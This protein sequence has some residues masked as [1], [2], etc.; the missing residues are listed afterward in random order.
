MGC[1][2]SRR[3]DAT[4]A[5]SIVIQGEPS[6]KLIKRG[7]DAQPWKPPKT[8]AFIS[9]AGWPAHE[10]PF[11]SHA[12]SSFSVPILSNTPA[13]DPDPDP[14][15]GAGQLR[16]SATVPSFIDDGGHTS[17]DIITVC[18]TDDGQAV[19]A[20]ASH[21]YSDF[22]ALH[23][24]L[25]SKQVAMR[26]PFPVPKKMFTSEHVKNE[27]KAQLQNYLNRLIELSGDSPPSALLTFLG[28]NR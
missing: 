21:R 12:G 4:A 3:R 16:L 18:T 6:P 13:S 23:W 20:R 24:T 1:A 22:L 15:A 10:A 26:F 5:V 14:A 27:R 25:S 2:N 17:Y 11:I 28:M 19:E 7:P 8:S 9:Y